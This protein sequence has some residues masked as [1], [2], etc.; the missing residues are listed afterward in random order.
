MQK[1]TV[2]TYRKAVLRLAEGGSAPASA[3]AMLPMVL[4]LV[5]PTSILD[6]GCGTGAWLRVA[7]ELRVEDIFGVDGGTGELV[8]PED[9]FRRVDLEHRLDLGRRFDLAICMEVAEHLSPSR[10]GSARRGF[11]RRCGR[12]LVLRSDSGSGRPG[13]RGAPER[14][15]AVLLGGPVHGRWP[16]SCGRAI[17]RAIWDDDRGSRSGIGRTHF[18]RSRRQPPLN[19]KGSTGPSGTLCTPACGSM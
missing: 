17:R 8:I 12:H 2:G 13:L 4:D 1:P 18:S 6:V 5:A 3:G 16:Q 19:W 11:M 10:A 9:R 14:T 15:M 7:S